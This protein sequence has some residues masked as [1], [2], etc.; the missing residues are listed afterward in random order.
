MQFQFTEWQALVKLNR[1]GRLLFV[2]R[3]V[4]LF[5]YGFLS[6]ILTLYLAAL[7]LSNKQI[8]ILLT[9]TLIGDA[10][11]SFSITAIADRVGRRKMLIIGAG[12]MIFAGLALATTDNLVLLTAAAIIGT[13]SPTGSE[14]GA[15]LS[16]EQAT[17]PQTAPDKYRTQIF[18][19]YSLVGSFA[20]ALGALA[21]GT[22]AQTLQE[23]GA[24]PLDSY[25]IIVIIYAI[26]GALL[27]LIFFALS[28]AAEATPSARPAEKKF[29]GLHRSRGV[30]LK[31]SALFM[32][33]AFGG[34]LVIQS[35]IAYWF[36]L[37]FG[38]QPAALG[39]LFFGAN[40]LAGF[41]ALAAARV[42]A[43]FGLINTMVF[44]HIPSNLL[45]LLVPLMPNLPLAMTV[46]LLRYSISQM[47]VP[48]RQSYTMAVVD[49]DE[50]SAA[51]GITWI[52]RSLAGALAP[53]LTGL[54]FS[55]SLLS[56]P[57]FCAG[58]LK[59]AYDLALF[60]SFRA[61]K[62]PEEHDIK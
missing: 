46:L 24:M 34:G 22:L 6:V 1:D 49:A 55:N 7:G 48:T 50:R 39:A 31:L 21:G 29:L 52:A 11:L 44:T 4:R 59:I 13:I 27:A 5:A 36:Y 25:R 56:L 9:L 20:T 18:A 40:L 47:D 26:L 38:T 16:I 41:S 8:G 10:A 15:F 62:P 45:L 43:R 37:R 14:A 61:L 33:D 12:L 30:I 2:T 42:A 28:P 53:M 58:G 35:W 19:L 60:I 32:L 57:F 17:L 54:M 3:M 23:Y 51:A